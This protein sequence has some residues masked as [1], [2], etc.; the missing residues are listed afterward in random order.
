M[1]TCGVSV[2]ASRVKSRSASAAM[3]PVPG[4]VAEDGCVLITDPL[5]KRCCPCETRVYHQAALVELAGVEADRADEEFP[6]A[7]RVLLEQ[8][9]ERGTAVAGD[10]VCVLGEAEPN[11][12][13]GQ[14]HRHLLPLLDCGAADEK[15]DRD[16]LRVLD[17]RGEVD[18]DLR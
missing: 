1:R 7:V 13:L 3:N 14:E 9:R 12:F 2:P 6:T 16:A 11:R 15:R 4:S 18:H 8:A 10:S 5:P 17:T